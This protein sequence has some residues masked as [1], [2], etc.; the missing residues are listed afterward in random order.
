MP[1]PR[2]GGLPLDCVILSQVEIQAPGLMSYY[3]VSLHLVGSSLG[4][5]PEITEPSPA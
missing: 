5:G 2:H 1:P 3:E 4:P